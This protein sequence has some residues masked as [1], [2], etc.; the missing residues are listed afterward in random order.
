MAGGSPEEILLR[1]KHVLGAVVL[2]VVSMFVLLY[3]T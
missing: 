1:D 2:C 3:L